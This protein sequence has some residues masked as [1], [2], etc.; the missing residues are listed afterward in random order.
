MKSRE[1]A[2][3]TLEV[4]KMSRAAKTVVLIAAVLGALLV[5]IYAMGFDNTL[6]ERTFNGITVVLEGESKLT[7]KY[8]YTLA[9][10]QTFS[11]ITVVAKGKRSEL[12]ALSESDFRAVVDV[13]LLEQPGLQTAGIVVYSPNGIEVVSQSSTTVQIF[14]DEFTQMTYV[15]VEVDLGNYRMGE[16]ITFASG[17]ANPQFINI[18]GPKTEL[19]RISGAYVDFDLSDY[20]L[21]QSVSGKGRIVLRDEKGNNIENRYIT[22]SET[23]AYVTVALSKQK[24]IP[25]K[26]KLTGGK[27]S[28]EDVTVRLSAT[29]ITVSGTPELVDSM[30]EFPLE[31]DETVFIGE[32]SREYIISALLP[33]GV[34]NESGFSKITVDVR[35][36]EL[37]VR[38]IKI[39][40]GDIKLE[41]LPE[42]MTAEFAGGVTVTLVGPRDAFSGFD[43][44]GVSVIADYNDITVNSDG[45][46]TARLRV[47]TGDE[48]G[49]IYPLGVEYTAVFTV[50]DNTA[51]ENG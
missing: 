21:T 4:G 8:G 32:S 5:W 36:P 9:G 41:N 27:F 13:S 11:S 31:F 39:S 42:G 50:K 40:A 12:N 7:E 6:F 35:L 47:V 51:E 3:K 34:V 2:K 48:S 22:C 43:F 37:S 46:Y 25:V 28:Q 24:T 1:S 16:G 18:S 29:T 10:G 23:E 14:V 44:S 38:R 26:V 45:S 20:E 33:E 49:V 19:E 30:D 17:M 15:P